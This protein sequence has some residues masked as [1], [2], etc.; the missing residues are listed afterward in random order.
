VEFVAEKKFNAERVVYHQIF[1]FD[2]PFRLEFLLQE[3]SV[4]IHLLLLRKVQLEDPSLGTLLS[5]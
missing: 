1:A 3:L 4:P 5:R 2:V